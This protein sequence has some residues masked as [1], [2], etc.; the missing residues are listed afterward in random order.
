MSQN[1]RIKSA[2]E[3]FTIK[4]IL[5]DEPE[6]KAYWGPVFNKQTQI[7]VDKSSGSSDPR[8]VYQ[9]KDRV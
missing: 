5:S 4:N 7:R 6:R 9:L 2:S 1:T 3:S 8:L